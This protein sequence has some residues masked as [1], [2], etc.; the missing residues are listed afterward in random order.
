MNSDRDIFNDYR[1]DHLSKDDIEL[2]K[3]LHKQLRVV[4][5]ALNKAE[6]NFQNLVSM[7]DLLYVFYNSKPGILTDTIRESF[8]YVEA[9]NDFNHSRID[10]PVLINTLK[11]PRLFTMLL[12]SL[13]ISDIANSKSIDNLDRVT[14]MFETHTSGYLQAPS[15]ENSKLNSS[16][17]LALKFL[18]HFAIQNNFG[19]DI[20]EFK[21]GTD[22]KLLIN[23]RSLSTNVSSIFDEYTKLL[24]NPGYNERRG[25]LIE[26]IFEDTS[27]YLPWAITGYVPSR[28]GI[29]PSSTFKL[30][31]NL[32][33]NANNDNVHLWNLFSPIYHSYL[34]QCFKDGALR[35]EFNEF[36]FPNKENDSKI[37]KLLK[38]FYT[39]NINTLTEEKIY[40]ESLNLL[41]EFSTTG[42]DSIQGLNKRR[43][44]TY[45]FNLSSNFPFERGILTSHNP[46]T[47]SIILVSS[48]ASTMLELDRSGRIYNL[49]VGI[50]REIPGIRDLILLEVIGNL[51]SIAKSKNE[52]LISTIDNNKIVNTAISPL[53]KKEDIRKL[54]DIN[55]E[56]IPE[57]K[58]EKKSN[59]E[60]VLKKTELKRFLKSL[61]SSEKQQIEEKTENEVP[62]SYNQ[63]KVFYDISEIKKQLGDDILSDPDILTEILNLI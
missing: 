10:C 55:E 21:A 26:S 14:Q 63:T 46:K 3:T 36:L 53:N 12:N 47:I 41:E 35:K 44:F 62:Q 30:F 51:I 33:L 39:E 43:N 37:N 9:R 61:I 22:K 15:V 54:E 48:S 19:I 31:E 59:F 24:L 56:E 50:E 49:P 34:L 5:P 7:P 38:D 4:E 18:T 57:E 28:L 17:E 29:T 40:L 2:H 20:N 6:D 27:P 23:I 52:K 45:E 13:S 25:N 42:F 8:R 16:N 32:R 11:T 60:P 58:E 1:D